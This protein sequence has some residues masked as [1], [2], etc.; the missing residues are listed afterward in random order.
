VLNN[1]ALNAAAVRADLERAP[2]P[3]AIKRAIVATMARFAINVNIA[4]AIL[5]LQHCLDP[6]RRNL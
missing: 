3:A 4:N 5:T 1:R 6:V 2:D